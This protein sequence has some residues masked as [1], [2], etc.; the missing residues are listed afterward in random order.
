M[1]VRA[2]VVGLLVAAYTISG[3]T[4]SRAAAAPVSIVHAGWPEWHHATDAE[5]G[6]IVASAMTG[7]VAGWLWAYG[8]AQGDIENVLLGQ[9]KAG[10]I[11]DDTFA[12]VSRHRMTEPPRFSKPLRYYTKSVDDMYAMPVN[13]GIDIAQL[14]LCFSDT[15]IATCKHMAHS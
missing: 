1:I 10:L 7:L 15:P 4:G 5:K 13:R 8:T 3:A 14:L 6:Q 11:K 12:A 9:R 2:C